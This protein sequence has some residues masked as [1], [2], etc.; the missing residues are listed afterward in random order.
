MNEFQLAPVDGADELRRRTLWLVPTVLGVLGTVDDSGVGHLMN[1]SWLVPVA[2]EPTRLVAS[3]E[4]G[5]ISEAR[6][7]QTGAYAVSL[8]GLEHRAWGRAFAK[9]SDDWRIDDGR[10]FV[11]DAQVRRSARGAPYLAAAVGVLAGSAQSL[12]DLGSHRLWL[13]HVEEVGAIAAA[14]E[15]PAGE[16]AVG[17][18]G[19]HD[20][21]MNYGR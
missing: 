2:E 13:F 16:H 1:L 21:R 12:A 3:V 8:L 18:L 20:T 17:V 15:G 19:V 9:P 11:R 5:S 14:L 7:R 10:E 6:L 4:T